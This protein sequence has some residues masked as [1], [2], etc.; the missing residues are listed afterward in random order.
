MGRA[1]VEAAL[2]HG[3]DVVIVSGPVEIEYPSAADVVPVVTTEEMLAASREAFAACDGL[4]GVAAPCDYRP[5]KVEANKIAKTGRP[6]T[7]ELIETPDIVATLAADK[8]ERW[9]VGFA[10]ETED[11]H[12]RAITKLEQKSCDLMV[13]NGPQAIDANENQV[14]IMDPSGAVIAEFSGSKKDVGHGIFEMIQRMLID[15]N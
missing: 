3:H 10:L 12:F 4:I 7:L 5:Q 14:E 8:G 1:I 9:A 11:Q 13:I 15:R 6:L 2:E